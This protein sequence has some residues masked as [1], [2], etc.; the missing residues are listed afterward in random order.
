MQP[1]CASTKQLVVEPLWQ[2]KNNIWC[3]I[4][5][6]VVSDSPK[7]FLLRKGISKASFS[8]PESGPRAD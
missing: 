1:D 3:L 5:T 4:D 8:L 2:K 7:S 6:E